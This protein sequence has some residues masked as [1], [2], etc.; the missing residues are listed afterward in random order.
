MEEESGKKYEIKKGTE[1]GNSNQTESNVVENR[2]SGRTLLKIILAIGFFTLAGWG[3]Y[4]SK[5]SEY[6]K[7][8]EERKAVVDSINSVTNAKVD[9]LYKWGVAQ[10]DSVDNIFKKRGLRGNGMTY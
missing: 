3:L 6:E 9:S 1:S 10:I 2:S 5:N 7:L 4:E 8:K